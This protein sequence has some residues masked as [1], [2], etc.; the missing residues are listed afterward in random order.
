MVQEKDAA[1]KK[2]RK[3]QLEADWIRYKQLR[4]FKFLNSVRKKAYYNLL[5]ESK[6]SKDL[7]RALGYHG[8]K[9]VNIYLPPCLINPDKI[10]DYFFSVYRDQQP[11]P[12]IID[13]YNTNTLPD[14]YNEPFSFTV[15][16]TEEVTRLLFSLKSSPCGS[17]NI[18]INM[19]KY[20][21]PYLDPWLT[22]IINSC[23]M[24]GYFPASWKVS[25]VKPLPKVK[26][27][28]AFSDLRPISIP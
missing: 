21:S 2:Y 12:H 25:I 24:S 26:N 3:S 17:D 6:S 18:S 7:W 5:F 22:H 8:K 27:P 10:N 19:L 4:N 9:K 15:L 20:C 16:L 1:L 13:H 11:Y 28:L 14:L 23:L